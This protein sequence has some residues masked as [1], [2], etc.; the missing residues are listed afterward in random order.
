MLEADNRML[1]T[2]E[3]TLQMKDVEINLLRKPLQFLN[4]IQMVN[5]TFL[6]FKRLTIIYYFKQKY[7]MG[8]PAESQMCPSVLTWV[9]VHYWWK[10]LLKQ[11]L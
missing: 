9:Q 1:S 3:E 8:S 11:F 4:I 2:F 10:K 6:G 7:L 5:P